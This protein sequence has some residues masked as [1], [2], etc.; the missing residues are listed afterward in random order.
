MSECNISFI[1]MPTAKIAE[2]ATAKLQYIKSRRAQRKAEYLEMVKQDYIN[3]WWRKLWHLKVPSDQKILEMV[4]NNCGF[5]EKHFAY[6]RA[7][8]S[9]VG[10]QEATRLL[11]SCKATDEIYISTEDYNL[12]S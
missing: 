1:K 8:W 3:S 2:L 9:Y 10:E 4:E 7:D 12:I 6:S 11:I 5:M